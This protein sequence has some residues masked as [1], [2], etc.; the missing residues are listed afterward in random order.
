MPIYIDA[1]PINFSHGPGLEVSYEQV[2]RSTMIHGRAQAGTRM[3]IVPKVFKAEH[4]QRPIDAPTVYPDDTST[5]EGKV[6]HFNRVRLIDASIRFHHEK[7]GSFPLASRERVQWDMATILSWP[8][9][10]VLSVVRPNEFAHAALGYPPLLEA[11]WIGKYPD[12]SPLT[13]EEQLERW[14]YFGTDR[15]W[16]KETLHGPQTYAAYLKDTKNLR[17]VIL[18]RVKDH[19]DWYVANDWNNFDAIAWCDI[20]IYCWEEHEEFIVQYVKDNYVVG[21][22]VESWY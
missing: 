11:N 6:V 1:T 21:E 3:V 4:A 10:L 2:L 5:I 9:A 15:T 16:A 20:A 7:D 17:R 22:G 18:Q 19:R 12:E 14:A 8:S 13:I